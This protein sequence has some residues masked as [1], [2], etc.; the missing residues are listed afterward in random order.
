MSLSTIVGVAKYADAVD[1]TYILFPIQTEV[2][3]F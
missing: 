3:C 2:S 1:Y